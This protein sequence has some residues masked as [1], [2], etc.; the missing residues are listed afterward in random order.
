MTTQLQDWALS[1][2][3]E[4]AE[5]ALVGYKV[6]VDGCICDFGQFEGEA[7][8]VPYFWNVFLDGCHNDDDGDVITVNVEASDV[9]VFPELNG[10]KYVRL[11]QSDDGFISEVG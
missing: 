5:E 2:T 1:D 9:V 11:Y 3:K 4:R 10:R 8:Y 6:D 7:S